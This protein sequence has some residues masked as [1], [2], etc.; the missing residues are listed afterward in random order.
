MW[1]Q[2]YRESL[3]Q[4][5]SVSVEVTQCIFVGPPAVGKSTLKH[6][7]V[8]NA[9]KAVKTSTA[10]ID[11][12]EVV[13]FSSEQYAVAGGTC[14]WQPVG[15]DVMGKSLYECIAS[16]AY[17]VGPELPQEHSAASHTDIRNTL[18]QR[19]KALFQRLKKRTGVGILATKESID[20]E[21]GHSS[22]GV[23]DML[24][25]LRNRPGGIK[26]RGASFIHLLDTGGQPS[27]QDALPLLLANPCTYLQIFNAARDLDQPVPITYRPDDHTEEVLPASVETGWETMLRSFSSMQTMAYKCSKELAQFQ[28]EGSQLPQFRIFVVGTFKDQLIKEG[29]HEEAAQNISEHLSELEGKPYYHCIKK[30]PTGQPFYLLNSTTDEEGAYVNSLRRSLSSTQASFKLAVPLRWYACKQYTHNTAQKFFKFQ[31]LKAICLKHQF[32][33]PNGAKEQ[34]YSLLKLLSLLGFYLFFELKDVPE[35]ANYICTDKGIFLKEVSKLLA[36]QF[37]QAPKCHAVEVFKQHGII[38]SNGEVFEELGIVEEVE[39]SWFLAALQHV[40]LLACYA[41][42]TKHSSSYFMPAALPQGKTKLPDC[43]T[44]AS[45]CVTFEFHSPDNPLVYT[46]LPRGIFCRLAVELSNGPWKPIPKESDRTTVKFYSEEFEL[47]LT[48]APG[49][50][51]LT[52]I[53]MEE[54]EGKNPLAELHKLCRCMYDTLHKNIVVSAEDVLGEQFSQ[55]AKIVFG[56]ECCCRKVP[57]LATPASAKARTLICQATDE[58]QRCLTRQQIWFVPVESAKVRG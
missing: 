19:A 47:Y 14:A 3:K 40:G 44:M 9:P 20:S 4:H 32:I 13:S 43:S 26:L 8:H 39:R 51:T 54:L 5:G 38:S 11:T 45:L 42:P 57:H 21:I 48:E 22:Q 23:A 49:F 33:D 56:V 52:P 34:F 18:P 6:L 25:T 31:D 55:T 16:K 2:A 29:K 27:F 36:V 10:V 53:L 58:R 7:L 50:I 1:Q 35:K 41:S 15:D 30:D 17:T 46:D 37:I 28:M 24:Y 12:P